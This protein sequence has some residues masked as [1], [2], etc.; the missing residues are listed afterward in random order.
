[1]ILLLAATILQTLTLLAFV[2]LPWQRYYLPV[3]PYA[4]LWA[5]V[6]IEQLLKPLHSLFSHPRAAETQ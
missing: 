6:G 4:C 1:M 3:V 5:A 2:P